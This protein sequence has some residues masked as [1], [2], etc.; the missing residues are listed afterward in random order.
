MFSNS[1]DQ[2]KIY[3]FSNFFCTSL[4]HPIHGELDF[5]VTAMAAGDPL[6]MELVTKFP[7]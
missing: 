6:L 5:M 1:Y 4:S 2:K 3:I 7:F